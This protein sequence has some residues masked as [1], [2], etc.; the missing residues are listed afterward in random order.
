MIRKIAQALL[1][2]IFLIIVSAGMVKAQYI[3][4]VYPG[5]VEKRVSDLAPRDMGYLGGMYI[6]WGDEQVALLSM[7]YGIYSR[8][9]AGIGITWGANHGPD[10]FIWSL[11][12]EAV[13]QDPEGWRPSLIIGTGSVRI[14]GR[15]QSGFIQLIK[16]LELVEDRFEISFTGGFATD[17]SDF[18]EAWG[19][20][21]LSMSF[22]DIISPFYVYDGIHSHV[23][24]TWFAF[25]GFALSVYYQQMEEFAVSAV[26]SGR[27]G[28][29][30]KE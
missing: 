22:S 12:V 9:D 8:I 11:R 6:P 15:D 23:G 1:P 27:H 17:I 25:E 18:N 26:A 28:D 21:A 16:T 30:D 2:A 13:P 5:I 20:G 19:L 3:G 24:V 10:Y 14:G 4:P 29:S 7:R